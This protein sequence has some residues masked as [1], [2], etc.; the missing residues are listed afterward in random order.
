MLAGQAGRQMRQI[1]SNMPSFVELT[2]FLV[3]AAISVG[4]A[5]YIGQTQPGFGIA[6]GVAGVIVAG[7]VAAS[8]KV[9]NQWERGIVLRLGEFQSIRGQLVLRDADH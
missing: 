1:Q 5:I 4:L 8:I 9:A 6:I 7:L 3:I 2:V